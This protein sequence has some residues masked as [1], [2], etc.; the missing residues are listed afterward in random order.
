MP[1]VS[2]IIPFFNRI[3]WLLEAVESV[4]AQTYGDWEL[5]VVDDG[6]TEPFDLARLGSDPRITYLRQDNRGAAAARNAGIAR[7]RG[8]FIAFL[9]ADDAFRPSKL[10]VQ[11]AF[12]R[13]HPD[14]PLSHT[15]Y[16]RVRSDG[17]FLEHVDSGGF[18]GSVYPRIV[19]YCPIAT[20][21]VMLRRASLGNLRFEE[22]FR[23]GEDVMLWLRIAR[24]GPIAGIREPLSLVRIHGSNAA[25]DPSVQLH[26]NMEIVDYAMA[27]DSGLDAAFRAQ[28]HAVIYQSVATLHARRGARLRA[29]A[30]ILRAIPE[31][32]R[33]HGV[34][35]LFGWAVSPLY[36]R[37]S[38]LWRKPDSGASEGS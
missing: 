4:L 25:E 18:A 20:P 34:M 35:S 27:L 23:T 29:A 30:W 17:S 26:A 36:R 19:I 13:A 10:E 9:D 1:T 28:A 6:S 5:I 12:M 33:G 38:P 15:S 3:E 8:E 14:T 11:V 22:R 24:L 7:A 37:V 32:I 31:I 2:I 21:T 16:T